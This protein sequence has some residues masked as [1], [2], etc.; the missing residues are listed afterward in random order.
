LFTLEYDFYVL[1]SL[2]LNHS[3]LT[4]S[5]WYNQSLLDCS[6]RSQRVRDRDQSCLVSS[7]ACESKTNLYALISITYSK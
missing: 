2:L 5:L 4:S 3:L 1:Y 6:L 7:V